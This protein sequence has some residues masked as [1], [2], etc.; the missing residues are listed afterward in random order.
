MLDALD[1]SSDLDQES[2]TLDLTNDCFRFVTGSFEVISLSAPHI[3]HSAL[4][5]SPKTSIVQKLYGPQAKPLARVV[6]GLP[7]SWD[8]SI[9]NTK[10]PENIYTVV[11]SPCSR[12]IAIAQGQSGKIVIL[13]AVTLE[14]LHTMQSQN[15]EIDDW[16]NLVYSPDGHLLTS[17]AYW[18]GSIVSWDLQTGGLIGNISTGDGSKCS[19]MSYSRCGTMLGGLFGINTIIIYNILSGTQISSHSVPESVHTIW[20]QGDCLQ[21]VA[22]ELGSITIWEVSF[23][24]TNAPVQISSLPTPDNLPLREFVLLPTLYLLAFIVK[25]RVLVW[26][27]QYQKTLLDS[28]DVKNP[29]KISFSLGGHFLICETCDLEFYLWKKSPDG[30]LPHQ[31]FVS[32]TKKAAV[33]IS[34]DGESIVSSRL[35]TLQLWHIANSSTSFT[36]S[37]SSIPSVPPTSS[38]DSTLNDINLFFLEFF[39]DE[40]LVA[41]A[42]WLGN[43][44]TV[45]DAKS[46]NKQLVIDTGTDIQICGIGVIGR[47][48]IAIGDGKVITWDLP[49]GDCIPNTQR[50]IKKTVLTTTLEHLAP[51]E[52]LYA[53]IS[54]DLS[55]VA[56]G[57]L[58]QSGQEGL[59]IYNIHTG[60]KIVAIHSQGWAPGFIPGG[61]EVWCASDYGMVDK[62]AIV[63]DDGSETIKLEEIW[64]YEEPLSGFPWHSSC[65]YQVTDDGWVLSPR[66]KR[67]LYL[68]YHWQP[69]FKLQLK[70]NG[71]FLAVW[72]LHSPA[73]VILE[74]E[75]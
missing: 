60:K 50:N 8:P 20:T 51:D 22:V 21:F 64:E 53:S 6:Q 26:D 59:R 49:V 4:P 10:L 13:D 30:Y 56:F 14:Q 17:Y 63:K 75:V 9:A 34:P 18:K 1:E 39:P 72:N 44:I 61:N 46:G 12:F 7:D 28:I 47:K 42:Q 70:W 11:W 43:T 55:Y 58:E 48:I 62:W 66:G 19:L 37:T 15:L 3:Y 57:N 65:G 35:T 73:P 68:P 36:S 41:F 52:K 2:P 45:L 27:P 67:L 32:S 24:S 23:T 25:G 33:V 16:S 69:E 71:N 5:L 38:L 29:K 54:P 40:P 31:Q 74:L